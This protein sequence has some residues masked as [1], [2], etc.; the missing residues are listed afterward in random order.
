MFFGAR[1]CSF[2]LVCARLAPPMWVMSAL[3]GTAPLQWLTGRGASATGNGPARTRTKPS[4][5]REGTDP[6]DGIARGWEEPRAS[7]PDD[8]QCQA[9]RGAAPH[10]RSALSGAQPLSRPRRSAH[11]LL[12]SEC[13]RSSSAMCRFTSC[14]S[15]QR[16][17]MWPC[18]GTPSA[19]TSAPPAPRP[20]LAAAGSISVS[21]SPYTSAV[22]TRTSARSY[23]RRC[24]AAALASSSAAYDSKSV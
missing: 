2:V 14:V 13:A 11:D 5:Q 10:L 1:L 15:P 17:S 16:L 7:W 23:P 18:E 6:A 4:R 12:S 3:I 9:E 24:F 21:R 8:R 22:A 19:P 20:A